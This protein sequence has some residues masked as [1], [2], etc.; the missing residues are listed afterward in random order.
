MVSTLR[1]SLNIVG[2]IYLGASVTP[3]MYTYNCFSEFPNKELQTF[4]TLLYG[5]GFTV[6]GAILG[7]VGVFTLYRL[8]SVRDAVNTTSPE[9][10]DRL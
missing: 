4:F 5:S 6:A 8:E 10:S 7:I 2:G 1:E 3:L 9:L